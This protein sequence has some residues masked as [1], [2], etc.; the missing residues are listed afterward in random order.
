MGHNEEISNTCFSLKEACSMV[1]KS[2]ALYVRQTVADLITMFHHP[3]AGWPLG[4]FS[5]LSLK[6][7]ILFILARE[8]TCA[9]AEGGLGE[10]RGRGKVQCRFC[11]QRGAQIGSWSHDLWDHDLSQN[12][13]GHLTS[14]AIQAPSNLLKLISSSEK[15]GSYHF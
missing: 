1:F 14:W 5:N 15:W 9:W 13:V 2:T 7:N 12:Q 10:G 4:K 6:K 3:S 8:D 11:T